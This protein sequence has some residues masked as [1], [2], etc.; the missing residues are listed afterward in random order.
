MKSKG[1]VQGLRLSRLYQL[2]RL[3]SSKAPADVN[4]CLPSML[5]VSGAGSLTVSASAHMRSAV[6]LVCW[7]WFGGV[8][9]FLC[10]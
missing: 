9:V 5:F 10:M 8:F 3:E 4:L 7:W 1:S 2:G 6:F